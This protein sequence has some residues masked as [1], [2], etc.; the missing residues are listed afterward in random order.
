MLCELKNRSTC[1]VGFVTAIVL[2]IVSSKTG[3][4]RSFL[5]VCRHLT[6]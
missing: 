1:D 4:P 5:P 2:S 6:M 3:I